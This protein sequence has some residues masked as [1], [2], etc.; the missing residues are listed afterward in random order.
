[1]ANERKP[2]PLEPAPGE[3]HDCWSAWQH[4]RGDGDCHSGQVSPGT[5]RPAI[6][7]ADRLVR[8]GILRAGFVW[9]GRAFNGT[10]VCDAP[11][12]WPL[13]ITTRL[14]PRSGRPT[15]RRVHRPYEVARGVIPPWRSPHRFSLREP[16]TTSSG[17]VMNTP[18]VTIA[19]PTYNRSELVIRAI[20]S[21]LSQT[22]TDIEVVVCNDASTDDTVARIREISDPRLRLI[23]HPKNIGMFDNLNF[24][25]EHARGEF[26]TM[27]MDDDYLEPSCIAALLEPWAKYQTLAFSY[28]QFW[29]SGSNERTLMASLGPER[30]AGIDY[31][32]AWWSGNRATI[33]HST[34]FRTCA[35]RAIGGFPMLLNGDFYVQ[36][37]MAFEG[38]VA[39]VSQPCSTYC[40]HEGTI[41]STMLSPIKDYHNR[42]AL[43]AMC[44]DEIRSRSIEA[45]GDFER[46]THRRFAYWACTA[47]LATASARAT[48]SEILRES[49]SLRRLLARNLCL[50]LP[51]VAACASL[52]SSVLAQLRRAAIE[53]R[54]LVNRHRS[55]LLA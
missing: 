45:L 21:A 27:L 52:P 11:C 53:V 51:V 34:L 55:S 28:G 23:T 20:R 2:S 44:C 49:W 33:L 41:S 50:A 48:K 4:W 8:T 25:L 15:A 54:A 22:F 14:R 17:T 12:R 26:F 19:L 32:A 9:V 29:S 43:F 6:N 31:I 30:E 5:W 1:M 18:R 37:R 42:A 47:L 35:L 3:R 24:G 16:L 36:L 40:S 46:K 39:H 7:R 38:D 10:R 13:F